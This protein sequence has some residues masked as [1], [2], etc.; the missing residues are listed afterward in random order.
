MVRY[1][2]VCKLCGRRDHPMSLPDGKRPSTT[3]KVTGKCPSSP[4]GQH[5]PSW[6]REN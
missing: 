1:A 6:V 5:I 4:N 2:A 3:P